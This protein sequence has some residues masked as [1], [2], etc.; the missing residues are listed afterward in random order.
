[1]GS[2]LYICSH[3]FVGSQNLVCLL[4]VS[5]YCSYSFS[6][7][8]L[9]RFRLQ[10]FTLQSYDFLWIIAAKV[11]ANHAFLWFLGNNCRYCHLFFVCILFVIRFC[12]LQ[13]CES[14]ERYSFQCEWFADRWVR[15]VKCSPFLK[16]GQGHPEQ[17]HQTWTRWRSR[18]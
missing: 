9:S 5:L 13:R 14:R 10:H 7:R 16:S 8:I 12:S 17:N 4:A 11:F 6:S 15:M 3:H 1:M 2:C 18:T